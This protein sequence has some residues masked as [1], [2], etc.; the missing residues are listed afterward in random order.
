MKGM[1]RVLGCPIRIKSAH[2]SNDPTNSSTTS[3]WPRGALKGTITVVELIPLTLRGYRRV[4]VEEL[5]PAWQSIRKGLL[6]V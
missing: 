2:L 6:I 3:S 5:I 4:I 1:R